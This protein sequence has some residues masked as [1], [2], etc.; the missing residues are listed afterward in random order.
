MRMFSIGRRC[1]PAERVSSRDVAV[2][3]V[4]CL[5]DASGGSVRVR[6]HLWMSCQV[7]LMIGVCCTMIGWVRGVKS[8]AYNAFLLPDPAQNTPQ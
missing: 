7:T 5:V 3:V 8:P 4:Q 2:L 6:V 1:S